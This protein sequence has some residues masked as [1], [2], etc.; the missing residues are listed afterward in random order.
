MPKENFYDRILKENAES[1]FLALAQ[2]RLG[3]KL[4]SY[5]P[6]REKLPKTLEREVDFLY[7]VH[8]KEHGVFLLH[9]EFQSTDDKEMLF[10]M[11]E[12][13]ALIVKKYKLPIRHMVIY[14]GKGVSSM[15][16]VLASELVFDGFELLDIGQID[17]EVFLSSQVPEVIIMGLLSKFDKEETESILKR[18]ISSLAMVSESKAMLSK[19][20]N[21]LHILSGLRNLNDLTT[22]TIST[23]PIVSN[24]D[25]TQD[26]WYKQG[27]KEEREAS[28]LRLKEEKEA[29][30]LRLKEEKEASILRF[31]K[32]GVSI[33]VIAES[34]DISEER[35]L[36]ILKKNS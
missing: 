30:I 3:Y 33:S 21:Q 14:L 31:Y 24:F 35:V 8:T 23:M 5:T 11:G 6:L 19:Y 18:I 26:E 28:I 29:S 7:K 22:K 20:L 13:H 1:L 15:S 34:L 25:Y 10:R 17:S 4:I 9:I 2:E 36:V 32:N 16:E 27:R 12:Y